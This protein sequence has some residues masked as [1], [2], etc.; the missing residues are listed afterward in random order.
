M[1][2][3]IINYSPKKYYNLMKWRF[4]FAIKISSSL[5]LLTFSIHIQFFLNWLIH[6]ILLIKTA[7]GSTFRKKRNRK[8]NIVFPIGKVKYEIVI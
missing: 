6:L 2:K 8:L 5:I 1:S 3:G 4:I 7:S